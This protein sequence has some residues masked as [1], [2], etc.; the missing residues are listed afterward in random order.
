VVIVAEVFSIFRSYGDLTYAVE[1]ERKKD[2]T[3][4]ACVGSGSTE[5]L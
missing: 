1:K 3:G 2:Y 5:L 4:S